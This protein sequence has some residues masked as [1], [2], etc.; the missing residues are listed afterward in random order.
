[1]MTGMTAANG[2]IRQ[3]NG[4]NP[5]ASVPASTSAPAV[6]HG[7]QGSG[8]GKIDQC[9]KQKR[10][11]TAVN[12]GE[13]GGSAKRSVG[14]V[15]LVDSGEARMEQSLGKRK[16]DNAVENMDEGLYVE[17]GEDRPAKVVKPV[18]EESD[19]DD[20]DDDDDDDSDI[21][22]VSER[23]LNSEERQS[24]I[25]MDRDRV[26]KVSEAKKAKGSHR[27]RLLGKRNGLGKEKIP[28]KISGSVEVAKKGTAV[29]IK[30]RGGGLSKVPSGPKN[31]SRT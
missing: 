25:E 29:R 17:P 14:N 1:M 28:T 11:Y 26:M 5:M 21:E 6:E 12:D 15:G 19:S 2:G 22:F 16:V 20:D 7:K 27:N 18:R 23:K 13:S 3:G 4:G 9:F 8:N 10:P 31:V 24:R 30:K